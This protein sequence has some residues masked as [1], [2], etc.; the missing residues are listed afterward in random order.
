M[1]HTVNLKK[2]KELEERIKKLQEK[3]DLELRL[4]KFQ[5]KNEFNILNSKTIKGLLIIREISFG[6]SGKVLE[7]SKEEKYA[8]K[9]MHNGEHEIKD[10]RSFIAE[11]EKI[12][13]LHHPNIIHTYVIYMSDEKKIHHLFYLNI[14]QPILKKSSKAKLMFSC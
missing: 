4:K 9:V 10:Y 13:I 12:N 3:N 5:N 8:L 7:V 14:V 11:Y 2:K 6:V 1:I